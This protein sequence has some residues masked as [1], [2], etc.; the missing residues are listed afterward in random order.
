[1]HKTGFERSQSINRKK[2]SI[3]A[4]GLWIVSKQERDFKTKNANWQ[5]YNKD[6]MVIVTDKANTIR[7]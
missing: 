3:Q 2:Q 6:K 5:K 4:K 1:M 7:K